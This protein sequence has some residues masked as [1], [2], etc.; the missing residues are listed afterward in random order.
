MCVNRNARSGGIV[1]IYFRFSLTLRYVVC[2]QLMKTH[3]IPFS[4]ERKENT[5]KY[6]ESAAM[7]YF[8]RDSRTV[9]EPSVFEHLKVY[10]RYI[11]SV[12][13]HVHYSFTKR[14]NVVTNLSECLPSL[15]T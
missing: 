12:W 2:Y 10:C 6:S 8:P 7:G 11:K 4:I 1:G 14:N 3:N 9:K 15:A 13:V 5:L